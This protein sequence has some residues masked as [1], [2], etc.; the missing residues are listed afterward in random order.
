VGLQYS[1]HLEQL[2]KSAVKNSIS[3]II[4][5]V[6]NNKLLLDFVI[7]DEFAQNHQVFKGKNEKEVE[8][9]IDAFGG[10]LI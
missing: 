1:F 6:T 8:E 7:D 4:H 3:D 2:N 9:I 5:K 10:E